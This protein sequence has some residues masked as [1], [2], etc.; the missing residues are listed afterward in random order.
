MSELRPFQN[1]TAE[2]LWR[3]HTLKQNIEFLERNNMSTKA[4]TAKLI[5]IQTELIEK[6]QTA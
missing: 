4:E 6:E 3:M 2:L 5:A 1:R